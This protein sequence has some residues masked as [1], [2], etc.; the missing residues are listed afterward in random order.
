MEEPWC[1]A[2][3]LPLWGWARLRMSHPLL[4]LPCPTWHSM[5]CPLYKALSWLL[6]FE[7]T[8]EEVSTNGSNVYLDSVSCMTGNVPD[9]EL[10]WCDAM[11]GLAKLHSQRAE[12]GTEKVGTSRA[13]GSSS[14]ECHS[15][16]AGRC[17][18]LL[19]VN[20]R[21]TGAFRAHMWILRKIF[22]MVSYSALSESRE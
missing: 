9:S 21:S 19:E 14:L 5:L 3:S 16:L 6:Q 2:T 11:L 18:A 4:L 22:P 8:T 20:R 17:S 12:G 15:E 13:S 1:T 10:R 7:S